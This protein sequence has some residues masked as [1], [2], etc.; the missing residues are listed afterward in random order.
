MKFYPITRNYT[1][2]IPVE[3][4]TN[5]V[6]YNDNG[7]T[8]KVYAGKE[9][10][11]GNNRTG[12]Y[13][14]DGDPQLSVS[15]A[16]H[17]WITVSLGSVDETNTAAPVMYNAQVNLGD[18]ARSVDVTLNGNTAVTFTLRQTYTPKLMY[19]MKN[20]S[21]KYGDWV[22]C[23]K[24]NKGNKISSNQA[25]LT[26]TTDISIFNGRNGTVYNSIDVEIQPY[27]NM[28]VSFGFSSD[29]NLD[30]L[31]TSKYTMQIVKDSTFIENKA[32]NTNTGYFSFSTN[33]QN[34]WTKKT[35][36]G[37]GVGEVIDVSSH[38]KFNPNSGINL[39]EINFYI[40]N[41]ISYRVIKSYNVKITCL[42]GG[43]CFID[44]A[45]VDGFESQAQSWPKST[46]SYIILENIAY[47]KTI[48]L[49]YPEVDPEEG[50]FTV[51]VNSLINMKYS[52]SIEGFDYIDYDGT[53]KH[54][55]GTLPINV[56][57]DTNILSIV[58]TWREGGTTE[59]SAFI[60][61]I[62]T[63]STNQQTFIEADPWPSNI[64]LLNEDWSLAS[65]EPQSG[66]AIELTANDWRFINGT[67]LSKQTTIGILSY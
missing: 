29:N 30:S 41:M 21:E 4:G 61:F 42:Q 51:M 10:F 59:I 50:G 66:I 52:I 26:S 45:Y 47:G 28:N 40:S 39:P 64:P 60:K 14:K 18:E 48:L 67:G 2:N 22:E 24:I 37:G 38:F 62:S 23:M 55:N 54:S 53:T 63:A 44:R 65:W 9:E 20:S 46:G 5:Q 12:M 35:P 49:T 17:S 25:P 3:G 6:Q 11:P 33:N 8:R 15:P 7:V 13:H 32:Y 36:G 34:S 16:E 1:I 19:M 58:K 57:D 43:D 27:R 56:Y 31:I